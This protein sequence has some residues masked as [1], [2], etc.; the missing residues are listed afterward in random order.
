VKLHFHFSGKPGKNVNFEDWNIPLEYLKLFITPEIA[1]L[2]S[3]EAN[4][5]LQQFL[6]NKSDLKLNLEST[7]E[8]AQ[9]KIK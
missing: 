6:E 9:T 2:I 5:Y 1:E 8:M 4:W 3:K 7:T